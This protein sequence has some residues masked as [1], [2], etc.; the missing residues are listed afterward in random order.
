MIA[1]KC[2]VG[3]A[4]GRPEKPASGQTNLRYTLKTSSLRMEIKQ[5]HDLNF[6]LLISFRWQKV[7]A[8]NAYLLSSESSLYF[9]KILNLEGCMKE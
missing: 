6:A 5:E 9:K 4:P 7:L 8:L 1:S 2:D 3:L